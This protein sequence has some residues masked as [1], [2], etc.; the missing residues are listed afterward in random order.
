MPYV[1]IK[2]TREGVTPEQKAALIHGVT[3][4][5]VQVLNKN[6]STTVVVIDE[7]EMD[8]WGIGGLPAAEFRSK[9]KSG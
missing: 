1:N 6:P 4:L 8:N 2:I 3:D 5:L 9:A 7:V